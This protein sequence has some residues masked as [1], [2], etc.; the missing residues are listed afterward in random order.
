M[1]AIALTA[2]VSIAAL[3]VWAYVRRPGR[4]AGEDFLHVW[5]FSPWGKQFM[6]DFWALEVILAL[7][8][9]SHAV[10]AGSLGLAIACVALMPIFGAMP[11]AVY[12]LFAVAV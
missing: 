10:E 6:V 5:S 1:F 8:M 2:L 3:S 7:W 9:I 4:L 12:W 11:A